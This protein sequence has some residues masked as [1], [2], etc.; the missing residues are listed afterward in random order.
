VTDRLLE[1]AAIRGVAEGRIEMGDV[2]DGFVAPF[3]DDPDVRQVVG[4]AREARLKQ[5][6]HSGQLAD[7]GPQLPKYARDR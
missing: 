7:D 3:A 6:Q 4:V 5:D 2:F 1:P